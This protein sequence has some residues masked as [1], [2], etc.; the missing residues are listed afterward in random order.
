MKRLRVF[1]VNVG[2]R[3]RLYPL[4]TPPLGVLYLAAYIRSK[5]DADLRVV[6]QR[7][8]NCSADEL[9]RRAL[10]HKADIIGLSCATTSAYQLKPITEAVRQALPNALIVLGG[11]H[12]SAAKAGALE[13]AAAD[14][15]VPGEGELTF[16]HIIRVWLDGGD[17]SRIPGLIW[18]DHNGEV[19][20]NPGAVAI[21]KDL[22]SLP[23][24]AYDL[25]DLR[26]Y[27]R[28]QSIAPIAR[29]RYV[30]LLSSRGCPYGCIWCHSIFG[31]RIRMH[32]AERVAEEIE[33]FQRT[34]GVD[35]FEFFDDTFNF[36]TRR[37]IRLTELLKARNLDVRLALP[38][39]IRGDLMT[40]EV[41]DALA[42]AG[43]Y[44]CGFSLESGSPRLQEYSCKRLDIARF[45]K[46]VDMTAARRVFITGFCMMGF[47]TET[48]AEL[49]QTID[50]ACA[51]QFHT[52]SFFTVTP[53]PGTP[54]YEMV[55]KTHPEK[56]AGIRYDEMDFSAMRVNLT[57]LPDRVLYGYQRKAQRQFFLSPRRIARI[58]RDYPKPLTLPVYIPIYLHRATKGLWGTK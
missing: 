39:A 49:Q 43:M 35:D 6:N 36:D 20:T 3:R 38:T 34:Y 42:D 45:L 2:L 30:S 29:R 10:E 44:L 31:K 27:W 4:V 28:A 24:P 9:T 50:V 54:L 8:E 11:A 12:A 7:L 40:Q 21:V 13:G 18:R 1:L 47:P 51:S 56:L 32:S 26:P 37:V 55:Q 52:S 22:D 53:F 41:V 14:A 57:D 58:L 25:I 23:M 16:E 48:E 5:F 33:Y 17:F 15:A 46:G 19:K